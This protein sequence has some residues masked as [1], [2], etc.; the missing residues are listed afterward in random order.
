LPRSGPAHCEGASALNPVC[1]G[2]LDL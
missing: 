1:G 2:P